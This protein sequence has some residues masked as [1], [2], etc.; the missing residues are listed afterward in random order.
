MLL[1]IVNPVEDEAFLVGLAFVV[2]G[3]SSTE[4]GKRL[5]I[6]KVVAW[7]R[8]IVGAASRELPSLGGPHLNAAQPAFTTVLPGP[9]V[10]D[11]FTRKENQFSFFVVIAWYESYISPGAPL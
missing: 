9:E 1:H 7:H 2:I 11:S 5:S 10:V 4:E 6:F 3:C 8:E